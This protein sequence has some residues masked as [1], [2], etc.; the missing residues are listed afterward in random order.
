MFTL[1]TNTTTSG[2]LFNGT[3]ER[4]LHA[5]VTEVA[6]EVA[7][8]GVDIVRNELDRVLKNPSTPGRYR[9]RITTRNVTYDR[10]DVHDN[11]C[12]YGPW[13]A[14]TG[15]RNKSTRFKGYK[16]WRIATLKLQGAAPGIAENVLH[17]YMARLN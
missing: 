14:G 5:F 17:R 10:S 15:S 3:A 6:D 16:H 9:A 11:N 4:A 2:P 8:E 13:L 7:R 12:V 1:T